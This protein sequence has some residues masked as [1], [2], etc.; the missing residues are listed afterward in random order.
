MMKEKSLKFYLVVYNS[1]HDIFSNIEALT[2]KQL[3]QI[4]ETRKGAAVV[5]LSNSA[6][7]WMVV[8]YVLQFFAPFQNNST[9]DVV[10]I[11][12]NFLRQRSIYIQE[13]VQGFMRLP[14]EELVNKL[15]DLMHQC[16]ESLGSEDFFALANHTG[17]VRLEF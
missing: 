17:S 16:R 10:G 15:I 7:D 9:K 2:R 5:Y 8:R 12:L 14:K 1:R 6:T 11:Y 4:C 3:Q 13:M